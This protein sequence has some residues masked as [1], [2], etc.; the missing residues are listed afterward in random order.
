MCAL[1]V[2]CIYILSIKS[3]GWSFGIYFF[4]LKSFIEFWRYKLILIL[5]SMRILQVIITY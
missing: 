4:W 1:L 3:K 5:K 2:A